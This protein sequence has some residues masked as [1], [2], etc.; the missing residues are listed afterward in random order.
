MEL[1]FSHEDNRVLDRSIAEPPWARRIPGIAHH[2][3]QIAEQQE[4]WA[5]VLEL[6]RG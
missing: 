6:P 3:R 2:L 4:K 1:Q 5:G